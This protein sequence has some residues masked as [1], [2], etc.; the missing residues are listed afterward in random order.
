MQESLK[1]TLQQLHEQLAVVEQLDDADR[2]QLEA[3]VREIQDSLDKD[4]VKSSDLAK[5]FYETTEQF[6]KSHPWLSRTAGQVA[7][8]LSQMGI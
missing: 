8:T 2:E 7:D 5:R 4:D 6:T 1:K 3:A